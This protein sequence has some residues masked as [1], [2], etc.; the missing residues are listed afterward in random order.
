MISNTKCYIIVRYISIICRSSSVT[1]IMND[2]IAKWFSFNI[3][4]KLLI[5]YHFFNPEATL[6]DRVQRGTTTIIYGFLMDGVCIHPLCLAQVFV[7]V[8]TKPPGYSKTLYPYV[9]YGEFQ[10]LRFYCYFLYTPKNVCLI[11]RSFWDALSF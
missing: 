7:L 5:L 11:F 3:S 8:C 9:T 1:F 10:P 2:N 6:V 4:I